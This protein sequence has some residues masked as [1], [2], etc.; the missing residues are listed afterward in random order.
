MGK[1]NAA[2]ARGISLSLSVLVHMMVSQAQLRTG[3]GKQS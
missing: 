1:P 3:S 2:Y